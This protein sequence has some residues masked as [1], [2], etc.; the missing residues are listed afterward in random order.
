M[1]LVN[2]GRTHYGEAL[3]ILTLDTRFPRIPGDVGNATTYR[4]PVRFKRV[5]GASSSR[6]ISPKNG[7]DR[8]LLEPFLRGAREL[9]ADGVR[10][11]TTTCGFLAIFQREM[12]ETLHVP[13]FTSSLL[14]VPVVS[15]LLGNE[16]TVGIV[17][18]DSRALTKAHL[19]GAGI[20]ESKAPIAVAGM[21]DSREFTSVFLHDSDQMDVPKV[22]EEVTRVCKRLV[23]S[24]RNVGALVFEDANLPPYSR[25]VQD[26]T[27]L[28]VFDIVTLANWV[29]AALFRESFSGTM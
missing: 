19:S 29:H 22:R 27:G 5:K 8:R 28:P 14:Q 16:R 23:S 10:A 7:T 20:D 24:H 1:S 11:I 25:F 9:E 6:V 21:Q 17:T 26:E 3:G 12:A 13:V 15:R 4:F 2:G 18:A